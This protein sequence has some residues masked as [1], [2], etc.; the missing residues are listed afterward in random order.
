MWKRVKKW[1]EKKNAFWSH[2]SL[3]KASKLEEKMMPY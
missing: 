3:E 2:E 1:N